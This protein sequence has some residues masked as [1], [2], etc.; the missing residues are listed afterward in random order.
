MSRD[1]RG[2][3][4]WEKRILEAAR[5]PHGRIWALSEIAA[6]DAEEEFLPLLV[7]FYEAA[8]RV[9]PDPRLVLRSVVERYAR[10]LSE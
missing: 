6:D 8:G 10:S 5:T 1:C 9:G 4:E 3:T 2:H 7:S